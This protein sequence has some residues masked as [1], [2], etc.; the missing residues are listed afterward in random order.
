MRSNV[1]GLLALAVA[2]TAV[3]AAEILATVTSTGGTIYD[4]KSCWTK[5]SS[6]TFDALS[7]DATASNT[8]T[9]EKCANYCTD[10][11]YFGV[12]NGRECYCG[13]SLAGSALQPASCNVACKGAPGEFCGGA[14][15]L[16]VYERA[17]AL[18]IVPSS[19]EF[20]YQTCWTDGGSS[21]HA[22]TDTGFSSTK[23]TV[24]KCADFC[25]GYTYF[26]VSGGNKC[27]CGDDIN[28]ATQEAESQGECNSP[29]TGASTTACGGANR[30]NLTTSSATPTATPNPFPDVFTYSWSG[31]YEEIPGRLFKGKESATDTMTLEE[32]ATFCHSFPYFGVE[33]G[34]ECFC[35]ADPVA[36]GGQLAPSITECNMPCAG[37]ST[38]ICGAGNRL[39]VYHDP[40]KLGPST[41]GSNLGSTKKGCYTETGAGRTLAAKGFGD[42]NLTLEGCAIGCV[43]YKYWGVEYGRECF[44]GNTIQ[45]AAELKA[46][47]E[48]NMVCAGNAAE[49]CGAGNRIMVYERVSD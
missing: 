14:T 38:E 18:E 31:C 3:Q 23:M 41:G 1:K 15:S 12:S 13:D 36:S 29:C 20:E 42:D 8:M 9:V 4:H 48:C 27:Y 43:G 24:P 32:C 6:T 2:V 10:Y 28:P 21:S 22:L 17:H 19:G 44:C 16:N 34:R 47:S 25:E 5:G 26:G 37:N 33:Y 40:A 7:D 11:K 46:D 30:V 49:L 45:P 35:G 39:S